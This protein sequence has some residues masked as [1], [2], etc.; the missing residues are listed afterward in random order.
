MRH[1]L[2]SVVFGLGLA[3]SVVSPALANHNVSPAEQ[4]RARQQIREF[5][6][7]T[8]RNW[9]QQGF[10]SAA[11]MREALGN[12]Q[13]GWLDDVAHRAGVSLPRVQVRRGGVDPCAPARGEESGRQDRTNQPGTETVDLGV[14]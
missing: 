10:G 5:F 8:D 4:T 6:L 3:V 9:S 12:S 1:K 11:A 13:S 7:F 14:C 2:L